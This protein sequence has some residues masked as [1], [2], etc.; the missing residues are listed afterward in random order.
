MFNKQD[1]DGVGWTYLA[2]DKSKQRIAT[3][4]LRL[5]THKGL[6]EYHPHAGLFSL[7][8]VKLSSGQQLHYPRSNV[9]I[10]FCSSLL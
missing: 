2:H 8:P 9:P 3:C 10:V 7:T 5:K 6:N 4:F 1:M